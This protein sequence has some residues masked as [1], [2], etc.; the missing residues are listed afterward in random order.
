M[1]Y[2]VSV[3]SVDTNSERGL[4]VAAKSRS[5]TSRISPSRRR[6]PSCAR[7]NGRWLYFA[8]SES[9]SAYFSAL[10]GHLRA[11]GKPMA[12]YS[13]KAGV[14]RVNAQEPA[15]ADGLTQFG[16]ALGELNTDIIGATTPAAKGR[17]ERANLTLQDRLVKELRL[18][19]AR[20]SFKP[21][22]N[23]P[24]PTSRQHQGAQG[25]ISLP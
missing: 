22:L 20:E 25:G 8:E 16:R 6:I 2:A 17:V 24:R 14:F 23:P 5:C 4:S 3:A 11:L 21:H 12:F 19:G 7:A 9:T 13:D 15:G 10:K 1:I 18:R